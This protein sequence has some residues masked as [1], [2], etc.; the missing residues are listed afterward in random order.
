M[1][2]SGEASRRLLLE[3]G[4]ITNQSVSDLAELLTA[5]GVAD[6]DNRYLQFGPLPLQD[7]PPGPLIKQG[8]LVDVKMKAE[9]AEW[10]SKLTP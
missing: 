10:F 6:S 2:A 3:K 8:A 5:E 7:E 1:Q 4:L 9:M